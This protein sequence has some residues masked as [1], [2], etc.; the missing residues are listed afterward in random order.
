[1]RKVKVFKGITLTAQYHR[2]RLYALRGS[3]I[4]KPKEGEKSWIKKNAVPLKNNEK[5]RGTVGGK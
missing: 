4:V 5:F 3:N 1:M 2:T